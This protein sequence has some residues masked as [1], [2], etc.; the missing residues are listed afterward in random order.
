MPTSDLVVVARVGRPHGV[1]GELSLDRVSL[2]PIE[3]H[4]VRE[5]TWRGARGDTRALTVHTA[6]P[7]TGRMLVHFQG[8]ADREA[9][10]RLTGGA[11]LAE[12]AR[13]PDPGPG[14]AYAFQLVGLEVRREDGAALGTLAEVLELGGQ[15]L[16]RV[17]GARELLIPAR[18]EFVKQVDVTGG[19]VT[20]TL[21]PGFE[22]L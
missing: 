21:P 19:V 13:L 6:R 22:E 15:T 17:R 1:H 10:A 8:V 4:A 16:Y 20:V 14:V 7:A 12:R 3:L 18:P 9:A 2:T 5:F 11:L